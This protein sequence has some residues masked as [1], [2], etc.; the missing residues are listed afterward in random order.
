MK[1]GYIITETG[2]I[3]FRVFDTVAGVRFACSTTDGKGFAA[4]DVP[5]GEMFEW[6]GL[7]AAYG[8]SNVLLAEPDY[9]DSWPD[10]A[11][12][13]YPSAP[14][15]GIA[16]GNETFA[17]VKDSLLGVSVGGFDVAVGVRNGNWEMFTLV[18]FEGARLPMFPA[19]V[20]KVD[21]FKDARVSA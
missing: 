10:W 7:V 6:S 13:R 21:E 8:A 11:K 5:D 2:E 1:S 19:W 20:G 4:F 9:P 14:K 3:A 18:E 12:T 17:L 15:R 16:T